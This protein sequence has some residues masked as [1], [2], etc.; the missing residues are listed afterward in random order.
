M[1]SAVLGL[2]VLGAA[3]LIWAVPFM[4]REQEYTAA[5]PQ[6]EPIFVES[7]I[8][9]GGGEEVCAAGVVIDG[10]SEVARLRLASGGPAPLELRLT[11]PGYSATAQ[12]RADGPVSVPIEPPREAVET[13]VCVRNV[14]SRQFE[15]AASIDRTNA[16]RTVTASDGRQFG[17]NFVITFSERE[18]RSLASGL[19]TSVE[20]A[21]A[22]RPVP[23]A[24]LWP[25]LA[26]FV[27][28]VP[29]GVL[30]AL[31]DQR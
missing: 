9:L 7:S 25:L 22:F 21:G 8:P 14:G 2:V 20:R 19:S 12:A 15:L 29:L 28:G 27:F 23:P 6:P 30:Y 11:G 24:V 1:R 16:R 26:L 5:T 18:P 4:T 13:T 31:R 17:Q 3:A 10:L